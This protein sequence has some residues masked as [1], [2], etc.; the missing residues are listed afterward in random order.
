MKLTRSGILCLLSLILACT[1]LLG[2]REH[3]TEEIA[4]P[5]SV[6]EEASLTTA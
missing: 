2:S 3:S 1:A 5:A 6:T 4:V